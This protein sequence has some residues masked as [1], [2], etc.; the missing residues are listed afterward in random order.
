LSDLKDLFGE[1]ASFVFVKEPEHSRRVLLG[2]QKKYGIE[3]NEFFTFYRT[4]GVTPVKIDA[5][6]LA[7]WEHHFEI[8]KMAG[9]DVWSLTAATATAIAAEAFDLQDGGGFTLQTGN[10][11]RR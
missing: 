10:A 6:E 1:E 4:F 2:F 5:K 8:F 9:G 11:G 3:T 7:S